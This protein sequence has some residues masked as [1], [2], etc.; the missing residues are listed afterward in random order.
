VSELID[1]SVKRMEG[2]SKR[3]RLIWM[4]G[5]SVI[6]VLPLAFAANAGR[7]LVVNAPQPSDALVVLA[8]ETEYRPRLG[9]RLLDK[10]YGRKLVIDVPAGQTIYEYTQMQL[11]EKYFGTL[12]EA[13]S[14]R[15]CPIYGMSTKAESHDVE[16]CLSPDEHRVLIVTSDYHTR[17]A[18]SIFR[19]ELRGRSFSAAAAHDPQEFGADW[20]RHREWA[21]TCLDEWLKLLWWNGVDRWL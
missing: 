19:K 20:W 4:L 2:P 21:K 13:A 18:L 5:S 17:R 7:A 12:P 11:A 3:R 15:I 10:G 9:L 8:G 6:A 1:F 14:I 16:K